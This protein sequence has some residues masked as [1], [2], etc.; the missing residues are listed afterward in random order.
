MEMSDEYQDMGNPG[1]GVAVVNIPM[2]H[3]Q[4]TPDSP[5]GSTVGKS[6]FKNR[7]D[8]AANPCSLMDG[9]EIP[10]MAVELPWN[11]GKSRGPRV[12]LES[13]AGFGEEKE[14][15][16]VDGRGATGR[17]VVSRDG[18]QDRRPRWTTT[19]SIVIV[20]REPSYLFGIIDRETLSLGGPQTV[21]GPVIRPSSQAPIS[22]FSSSQSFRFFH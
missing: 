1:G 3:H 14:E 4:H 21:L 5:L 13:R 20:Y 12:P 22:L 18:L 17:A 11:D 15:S 2:A 6:P 16:L 19:I 10:G 8:I 9:R 7:C